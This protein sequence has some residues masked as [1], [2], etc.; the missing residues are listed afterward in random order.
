MSYCKWLTSGWMPQI[1]VVYCLNL[2]YFFQSFKS[3]QIIS[4]IC[5]SAAT[6]PIVDELLKMHPYLKEPCLG[7]ERGRVSN[8]LTES[9][10]AT[11]FFKA[12]PVKQLNC[13]LKLTK[14]KH[15]PVTDTSSSS[16]ETSLKKTQN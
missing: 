3:Q 11:E 6:N 13:F 5:H 10:S 7:Q 9:C 16:E 12:L 15:M 2:N 1:F 14:Q 4:K 8:A